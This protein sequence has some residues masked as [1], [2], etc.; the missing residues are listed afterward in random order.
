[1]K[2]FRVVLTR[3]RGRFASEVRELADANELI[4]AIRTFLRD[5]AASGACEGFTVTVHQMGDGCDHE[6]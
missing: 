5:A 6:Q 3:P 1:V 2:A 4:K